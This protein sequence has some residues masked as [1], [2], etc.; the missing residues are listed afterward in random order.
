MLLCQLDQERHIRDVMLAV[1]VDGDRVGEAKL[2]RAI[3]SR[4]QRGGFA[5]IRRMHSDPPVRRV[6][7]SSPPRQNLVASIVASI[8]DD[9]RW[10]SHR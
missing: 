5:E 6:A 1:G 9:D 7:T 10:Q 2:P 3:E 8:V 4:S